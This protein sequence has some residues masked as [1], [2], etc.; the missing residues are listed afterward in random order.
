MKKIYVFGNPLVKEDSLPLQ[1]LPYLK[2]S[3]PQI[4]FEVVDPNENFPPENE[5]DLVI[6]D[7][8]AGIK[9]PKI[10]SLSDLQELKK[11]PN[12]PH[13]YD[14]GM[15]L[16]LLKKLKKIETVKIIGVPSLVDRSELVLKLKNIINEI[17]RLRA[18]DVPSLRMT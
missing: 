3:F 5:K 15:H 13:D 4:K 6:L 7:T 9:S 10:F 18:S 1:I 17:L 12:S 2:K 16:L 11:T 14:L 8:I